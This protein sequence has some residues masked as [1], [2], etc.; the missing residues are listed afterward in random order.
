[1]HEVENEYFVPLFTSWY[2][3]MAIFTVKL[4]IV[5]ACSSQGSKSQKQYFSVVVVVTEI[6]SFVKNK[7]T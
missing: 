4:C 6:G 2:I 3:C 5:K 7:L 1:M